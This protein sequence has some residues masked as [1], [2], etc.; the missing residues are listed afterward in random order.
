MLPAPTPTFGPDALTHTPCASK[1]V[2]KLVQ[3]RDGS[4]HLS[5]AHLLDFFR[6]K[7]LPYSF[8]DFSEVFLECSVCAERKQ[9][10]YSLD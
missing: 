8:D 2:S 9:Q 5:V 7:N 1:A 3:H 10:Y 6:F 4:C